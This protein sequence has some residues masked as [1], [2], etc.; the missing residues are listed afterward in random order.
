MKLQYAEPTFAEPPVTDLE[1]VQVFESATEADNGTMV[2]E[3][4]FVAGQGYVIYSAPVDGRIYRIRFKDVGGKVGPFSAPQK[5][6]VDPDPTCLVYDTLVDL[7]N[8]PVSDSRIQIVL[9]VP[10]A[11]YNGRSISQND[12]SIMTDGQGNWDAR[13]IPNS[14]I[15]PAGTKYVFTLNGKTFERIVPNETTKR[16]TD[17][18]ER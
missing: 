17:L 9:N 4:P 16:F 2:A 15:I 8:N 14:L 18:K 7:R 11:R 3:L 12:I 5:Y 10:N 1:T 6:S 13:L